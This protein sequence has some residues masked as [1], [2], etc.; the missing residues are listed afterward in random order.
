MD[1]WFKRLNMFIF[2]HRN[3]YIICLTPLSTGELLTSKGS[4][5]AS[6][7]LPPNLFTSHHGALTNWLERERGL[8]MMSLSTFN[9]LEDDFFILSCQYLDMVNGLTVNHITMIISNMQMSW[10]H[11]EY[12]ISAILAWWCMDEAWSDKNAIMFNSL[13][14]TQFYCL[15]YYECLTYFCWALFPLF[16]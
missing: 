16:V 7:N 4:L 9:C 3:I 6:L 10:R 14:L 13:L 8:L 2:T 1:H 12:N 5:K 15:L 11:I